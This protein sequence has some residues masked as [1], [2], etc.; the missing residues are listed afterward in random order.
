MENNNNQ[1]KKV[2]ENSNINDK[3]FKYI[4]FIITYDKSKQFKVYLSPEYKISSI[5]EKVNDKSYD[6]EN[7]LLT[8]DVYRL[9][10]IEDDLKLQKDQKEYQVPINVENEKYQYIIKLK[11]LNKD[12]YEYNFEIREL[13]I[14]LLDYQKQFEIYIDILRN[15]LKKKQNTPENEDFILSTESL[16][17]APNKQYNLLF[18]L[19]ILL[20]CFSTKYINMH[21]LLFRPEKIKDLGE[22][23]DKKL[24]QIK[25]IINTLSKK[26]EKIH[27]Q[28]E[29]D[30]QNTLESFYS[31]TLYFNLHFQKEKIKDML[32]NEQIFEYL[33]QKLIKYY[34]FFEGLILSK[35]DVIKLIKKLDDYN[36]ILNILFYLGKDV[37][38]FLEFINEERDCITIYFR[39]KNQ[40][41]KRR[42][43]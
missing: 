39:K 12:F 17:T 30:R 1:S 11:D 9:K 43:I 6:V 36:Q 4:Y 31:V 24:N 27:L 32:D 16:L 20:E 29:N 38:Q 35:K 41:I 19:S 15:K 23:S 28:N 5:L 40:K 2:E 8:S 22:V 34:N 21:F 25:N 14:L 18:Y 42:I 3:I 26:P 10:I 7:S 13:N 37:L 33:Y